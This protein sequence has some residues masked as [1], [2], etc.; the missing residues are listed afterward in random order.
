MQPV[1]VDG[2]FLCFDSTAQELLRLSQP[3]GEL[4]WRLPLKEQATQPVIAGKK[5]FVA[6]ESGNLHVIDLD[7]GNRLGYVKFAQPLR[8][9]PTADSSGK[10]LYAVGDHSSLYTLS[11]DDLRCLGVHYLGHDRGA[12]AVSP[13]VVLNKF[14]VSENDGVETCRLHL[15][16]IDSDGVIAKQLASPR[17]QGLITQQPLVDGRR[18]IAATDR[19][20]VSVYDITSSA[21]ESALNRLASREPTRRQPSS[22][23]IGLAAGHLWIGENQLTKYSIDPTNTSITVQNTAE[24]YPN[25]SFLAPPIAFGDTLVH[26]RKSRGQPSVTVTATNGKTGATYWETSVGLR[27][28]GAPAA[29]SSP[30]G[31]LQ[32]TASG[33]VF[34]FDREAITARV[35]DT[36]LPVGA[37]PSS[38]KPLDTRLVLPDGKIVFAAKSSPDVLLYDPSSPN[39]PLSWSHLPSSLACEP[40]LF[41]SGWLAPLEI[42]QVLYLDGT[43]KP[44]AAPFQPPLKPGTTRTWL[45]AET[46]DEKQFVI[47]DGVE[48]VAL[49]ELRP[50]PQPNL[51]AAKEAG[52]G[53]TNLTSRLA[54]VGSRVFAGAKD[55]RLAVFT[56]PELEAGDPVTLPG[57]VTWGPYAVG[58]RV[59]AATADGKLVAIVADGS[60]AWQQNVPQPLGPPLL[61]G[62]A[63]LLSFADGKL[64]KLQMADGSEAGRVD[65]KQPLAAAVA[66][67][68]QRLAVA[69]DDG[70][71]LILNL[72]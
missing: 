25:A 40:T 45:P 26:F 60:S 43:G 5:A 3:S 71:V 59:L 6:G 8:V 18:L 58:D 11:V 36:P 10:R 35:Q 67:F 4:A 70:S 64:L 37:A 65:L 30:R 14:A 32:A 47:S 21:D 19:G 56:L 57:E 12:I 66:E 46:V 7:S 69:T 72:P 28:A 16:E 55:A 27:P 23:V 42:G 33:K 51:N 63:V 68:E 41:G 2:D 50:T 44:L 48:N 54:T 53:A 13:V 39:R 9:P 49:V 62:D 15:F 22:S 38:A 17:L 29:T 20:H 1:V 61:Q 34:V 31:L 24:N 52:L